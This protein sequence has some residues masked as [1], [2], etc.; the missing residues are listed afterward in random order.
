MKE[1]MSYEEFLSC[2]KD[3][4][5]PKRGIVPLHRGCLYFKGSGQTKSYM[6]FAPAILSASRS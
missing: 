3:G 6:F 2:V 5:S 4:I 1:M